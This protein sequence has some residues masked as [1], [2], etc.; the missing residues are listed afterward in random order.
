[1]RLPLRQQSQDIHLAGSWYTRLRFLLLQELLALSPVV[2]VCDS[3][4][5]ADTAAMDVQG[6]GGHPERGL[7]LLV[8]QRTGEHLEHLRLFSGEVVCGV[9]PDTFKHRGETGKG[10][11]HSQN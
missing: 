3:G 9:H 6:A 8:C 11:L 2:S 1:M 5:L 10:N 7:D 4:F